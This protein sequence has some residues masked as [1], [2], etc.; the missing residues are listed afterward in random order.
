[1]VTRSRF[2]CTQK[3]REK[4][5]RRVEGPAVIHQ[6]D[7]TILVPPGF[8]AEALPGGSL[9]LGGRAASGASEP[10]P[11]VARTGAGP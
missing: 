3:S 4:A 7:S 11:E 10:Q 8:A 6:V 5:F 2:V 1:M 9:L